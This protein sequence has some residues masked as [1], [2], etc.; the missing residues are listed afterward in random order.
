[1]KNTLTYKDFDKGGV[2]SAQKKTQYMSGVDASTYIE[3]YSGE[4]HITNP[5]DIDTTELTNGAGWTTDAVALSKKRVF[6]AEPVTPYDVGDL[7]ADGSTLKIAVTAKS[8]GYDYDAADWELATAYTDDTVAT[9]AQLTADAAES[10]LFVLSDRT[11][12]VEQSLDTLNITISEEQIKIDDNTDEILLLGQDVENLQVDVTGLTNSLTETGGINLLKNSVGFFGEEYWVGDNL[13]HSAV[14]DV[15]NN[16]RSGQAL[17]P[18]IVTWTQTVEV[19]NG[20]YTFSCLYK[21]LD[22]T[23]ATTI[24]INDI[25]TPLTEIVWTQI[26]QP[27]TVSSRSV[28]I[29]ITSDHADAAYISDLMLNS[30]PTAQAWGLNTNETYTDTVK[31]GKGISVAASGKDTALYI[32]TDGIRINKVS[33]NSTVTDFTTQGIDTDR[34]TA[35]SGIIADLLIQNIEADGETQV[36]MNNLGSI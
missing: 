20:A 27:L 21:V 31:I 4:V 35:D 24:T 19:P 32:D 23:A 34:I 18:G 8:N 12:T 14:S 36:C 33:D 13:I 10:G 25:E 22:D 17:T 6:V 1:M 2:V 28:V 15:K 5:Q 30:G 26:A 9:E 16:T 29:T 3:S 7:W 11:S